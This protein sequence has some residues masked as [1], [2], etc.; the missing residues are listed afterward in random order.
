MKE[1]ANEFNSFNSWKGL[2]YQE[3]Y[4]RITVW[5]KSKSGGVL[6]APVEVSLDPINSCQSLYAYGLPQ[7]KHI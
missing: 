1:W 6:I 5:H 3:W 7:P 4:K 2:L